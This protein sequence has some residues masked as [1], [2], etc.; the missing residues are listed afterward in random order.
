MSDILVATLNVI[1]WLAVN[2]PW[3]L[4][5]ASGVLSPVLLAIKKWRHIQSE[6]VMMSLVLVVSI[7]GA[8][9][10]Y[11]LS[12]TSDLPTVIAIQG[13]MV[14]AMSQPWYY[15]IYKPATKWLSAELAKAKAFDAEVK[16]AAI[17]AAGLP[18]PQQ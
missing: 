13:L 9:A 17:P 10:S 15:I 2:I 3:D 16:S 8:T 18:T 6:K 12:S 14:A 5:L 1:N 11:I 7:A 4:V